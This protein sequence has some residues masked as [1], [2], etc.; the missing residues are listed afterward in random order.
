MM[1]TLIGIEEEEG[2]GGVRV[3]KSKVEDDKEAVEAID[4]EEVLLIFIFIS[5]TVRVYIVQNVL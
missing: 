4:I 5:C 3:G 2:E 1:A